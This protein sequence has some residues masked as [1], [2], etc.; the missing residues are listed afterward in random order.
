MNDCPISLEPTTLPL[1]LMSDPSARDLQPGDLSDG[2]DGQRVQHPE[3]DGEDEQDAQ[4]RGMLPDGR[5][6]RAMAIESLG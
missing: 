3:D 5:E 4:C 2:R 1:T 6:K